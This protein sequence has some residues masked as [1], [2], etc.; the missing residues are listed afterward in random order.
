MAAADRA[1]CTR[2]ARWCCGT[3]ATRSAR[4][5]SSWT[6][7]AP[8]WPSAAPTSTSTP[9]PAP[10]RSCTCARSTRTGSASRSGAGSA[11][12]SSSPWARATT[13]RRASTRFATGTPQVIG[14]V[15]VEE[16]ARLLGE[17][18]MDRL[19]AKSLALTGYLIG[20]ADEWLAPL[21]LR[22]GLTARGRP[23]RRA[24]HAAPPRGAAD[25][26]G[27]DPREGGRRLPDARP[28]A[29]RPGADHHQLH[30]RVGR[31]WTGCAGSRRTRPTTI[32]PP[33]CPR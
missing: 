26:P 1:W 6:P 12:A 19:R 33:S 13:R 30:R 11:S 25:Q 17:V 31:P 15:A 14:T 4:C 23:A 9:G 3:C 28:A 21:G 10:R 2:R 32:C 8:T 20:L 22:P 27:A 29:A 7:R 24:R 16:G 18:G 5:R